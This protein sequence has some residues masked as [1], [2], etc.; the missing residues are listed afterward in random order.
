[1]KQGLEHALGQELR[2][3][4]VG[5]HEPT[6]AELRR[7]ASLMACREI[8]GEV[9]APAH[10]IASIACDTACAH[11]GE[12]PAFDRTG[13]PT[14]VGEPTCDACDREIGNNLDPDPED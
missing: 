10:V 3:R 2:L 9:R 5:E 4:L 14:T 6:H 13:E 11:C 8:M 12:F 7:M 1:L